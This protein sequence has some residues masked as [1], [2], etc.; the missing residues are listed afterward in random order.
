MAASAMWQPDKRGQRALRGVGV[1]LDDAKVLLVERP[2]VRWHRWRGSGR[3]ALVRIEDGE[4]R[5]L[6]RTL[7]AQRAG[8]PRLVRFVAVAHTALAAFGL[9]LPRQLGEAAV[10]LG[11]HQRHNATKLPLRAR[12]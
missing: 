2:G 8:E 9:K 4:E 3:A 5:R 11:A 1:R 12:A 7:A 10:D 6:V